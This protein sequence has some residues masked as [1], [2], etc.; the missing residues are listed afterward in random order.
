M[1]SSSGEIFKKIGLSYLHTLISSSIELTS[2]F[3][4]SV[5]WRSLKPGVS[6]G[7]DLD[8]ALLLNHPDVSSNMNINGKPFEYAQN[9]NILLASD[10]KNTDSDLTTAKWK[11]EKL[12]KD[13]VPSLHQDIKD[14]INFILP[15]FTNERFITNMTNDITF[16]NSDNFVFTD[17]SFD[18]LYPSRITSSVSNYTSITTPNGVIPINEILFVT[19]T[20][21]TYINYYPVNPVT[22]LKI[23]N[24]ELK[25][26]QSLFDISNDN[27]GGSV[28]DMSTEGKDTF[29]SLIRKDDTIFKGLGIYCLDWDTN[30]DSFK[31]MKIIT[32]NIVFT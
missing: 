16:D 13:V 23:A 7:L 8:A 18:V 2:F 12:L 14:K 3:K 20:T 30:D 17:P 31:K 4:L 19:E 6:V 25:I 29:I 28:I 9:I 10:P 24:K 32:N 26:V 27:Y 15:S 21:D 11:V 5:L 1:L 22:N